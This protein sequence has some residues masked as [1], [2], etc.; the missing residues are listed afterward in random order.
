M[1]PIAY[2]IPTNVRITK[3][4]VT[5]FG[6]DTLAE[7]NLGNWKIVWQNNTRSRIGL[8]KHENKTIELSSF[9]LERMKDKRDMVDV[10]LHEI[11]HAMVGP[12]NGHG[13]VWKKACIKIGAKPER[14]IDYDALDRKPTDTKYSYHCKVHGFQ[15]GASRQTKKRYS[16]V[17]CCSTHFNANY[18]LT[19]V[20]NW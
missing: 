14:C 11:A 15:F 18:L 20:Q 13:K 16:C 10:V 2:T 6:Y 4:F 7:L 8:C 9:A 12:G 3:S 17:E 1:N 5:K 19:K